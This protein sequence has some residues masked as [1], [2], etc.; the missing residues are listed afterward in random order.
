MKKKAGKLAEGLTGRVSRRGFIQKAGI[1]GIGL[2]ALLV[3]TIGHALPG[4]GGKL[5]CR[6]ESGRTKCAPAKQGCP[7]VFQGSPLVSSTF[8]GG[9]GDCQ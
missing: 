4:N 9:C 2:A 3:P 1:F 8:V 6:Y 5:C 7:S